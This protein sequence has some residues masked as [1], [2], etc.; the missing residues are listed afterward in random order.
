MWQK[1]H[2]NLLPFSQEVRFGRKLLSHGQ[3]SKRGILSHRSRMTDIE[4]DCGTTH[5][6]YMGIRRDNQSLCIHYILCAYQALTRIVSIRAW[7]GNELNPKPRWVNVVNS[8][9][10]QSMD[11]NAECLSRHWYLY[12][13]G[14]RTQDKPI[15]GYAHLWFCRSYIHNDCIT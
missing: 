10:L 14:F 8:S 4:W 5:N 13:G 12:H 9:V 7:L 11:Y 2:V 15:Y 1:E 6:D 3:N